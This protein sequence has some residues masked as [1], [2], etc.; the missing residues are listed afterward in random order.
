MIPPVDLDQL[1]SWK[2]NSL[3]KGGND[4]LTVPFAK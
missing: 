4:H 3:P 1:L 2:I